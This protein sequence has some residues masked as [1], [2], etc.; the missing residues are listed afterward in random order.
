ML[1]AGD[2]TVDARVDAMRACGCVLAIVKEPGFRYVLRLLLQLLLIVSPGLGVFMLSHATVGG[3]VLM[4][5]ISWEGGTFGSN[6]VG[7]RGLLNAKHSEYFCKP[8]SV[9][10]M[11]LQYV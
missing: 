11:C 5:C 3:G 9:S 6:T 7:L 10:K 8:A 2:R 4:S 1:S